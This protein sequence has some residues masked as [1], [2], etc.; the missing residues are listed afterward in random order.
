MKRKKIQELRAKRID[1]L[2][3]LVEEAES[4]LVKLRMER[5][6]DKIKDTTALRKKRSE[7]AVM[8]T[9]IREKQLVQEVK[10]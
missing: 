4:Q 5:T 3:S 8:K 9:L 1:E 6:S 2:E 7:I 10:Q